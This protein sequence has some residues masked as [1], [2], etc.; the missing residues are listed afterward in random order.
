MSDSD[1]ATNVL[2]HFYHAIHSFQ[3][4]ITSD[5]DHVESDID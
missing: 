2:R 4:V 3:L 1:E 5:V